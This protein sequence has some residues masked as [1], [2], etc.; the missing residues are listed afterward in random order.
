[1]LTGGAGAQTVVNGQ[2]SFQQLGNV[3]TITNTPGTVIEWPGFSI[4]AGEVTRFVQQ[5]SAS[6]VLNRITGQEPSLIL[7]A[8]QSNGRVFL[9]NPNGVLFGA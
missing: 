4:A 5:N 6:A 8:L 7:G 2:A 9:I 1:M 3:R